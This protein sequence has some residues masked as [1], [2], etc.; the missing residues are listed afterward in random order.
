MSIPPI[1]DRDGIGRLLRHTRGRFPFI[2]RIFADAV[3]QGAKAAR[4]VAAT[5]DWTLRVDVVAPRHQRDGRALFSVLGATHPAFSLGARS[6]P[7][8]PRVS[9]RTKR[10][11]ACCRR[12]GRPSCSVRL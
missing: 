4:L 11:A 3:Y 10:Y 6:Q 7:N 2:E 12:L 8:A 5:G 9:Q 1:Q